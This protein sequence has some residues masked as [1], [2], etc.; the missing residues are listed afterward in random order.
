MQHQQVYHS[1]KIYDCK[2]CN[3]NFSSMEE[4]RTH[5]QRS[6]TYRGKRDS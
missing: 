5:M 1:D 6:H 2:K 4:M 3:M